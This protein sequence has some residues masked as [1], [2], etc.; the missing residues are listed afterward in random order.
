[1]ISSLLRKVRRVLIVSI[2]N[3]LPKMREKAMAWTTM[4]GT[5]ESGRG[6]S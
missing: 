4:P 3:A 5:Y 1:L 6:K 2:H